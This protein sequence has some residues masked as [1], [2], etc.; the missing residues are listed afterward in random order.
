M[1][2][3]TAKTALY[4]IK[5]HDLKLLFKNPE[6]FWNGIVEIDNEGFYK[7][8]KLESII[9]PGSVKRILKSAFYSCSNLKEVV[10]EEGIEEISVAPFNYTDNIESIIFPGSA[11]VIPHNFCNHQRKLNKV[12][13]NEGVEE[14]KENAFRFCDR[15][16]KIELPESIISLEKNAF[17]FCD[18]L[19]EIKLGANIKNI[20]EGCF[21][22]DNNLRRI[23]LGKNLTEIN[24]YAFADCVR[25][26]EIEIEEGPT[27]IKREAFR[28]VGVSKLV[29]PGSVEIIEDKAF[30][31]CCNL[32]EIELKEGVKK[33][34][35]NIFEDCY[36]LEKVILPKSLE[37]IS[38]F[39][40]VDS[41]FNFIY[42][43]N[44]G[45]TIL[46][47]SKINDKNI[48]KEYS[49]KELN[50]V[51]TNFYY[52]PIILDEEKLDDLY[53]IVDKFKKE[54]IKI[55]G[56]MFLT[57]EELD[58]F[59]KN[60]NM[61]NYNRLLIKLS[62]N[63]DEYDV[64]SV[65]KFAQ[66]LGMFNKG[67]ILVKYEGNLLKSSELAYVSLKEALK[68]GK[69]KRSEL[70][71]KYNSKAL[72]ECAYDEELLLKFAKEIMNEK[73]NPLIQKNK[74]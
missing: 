47:K 20:G 50:S 62:K 6:L 2:K 23:H 40:F 55:P 21:Q 46:S 56:K 43:M 27:C 28:N 16:E 38:T 72:S 14:I 70:F 68:L 67:D 44:N 13:I 42:K 30:A 1:S 19:L 60:Y 69:I 25:L 45:Q 29:I 17:A 34:G 18:G 33:I 74:R 7:C 26:E 65:M 35:F 15:L 36:R 10:F 66:N 57:Y 73:K 48:V 37:K 53:K 4:R 63:F 64:S 71:K 31:N 39:N 51:V 8:D 9:V 61:F 12:T 3:K 22:G 24:E 49:L 32:S 11:K 5:N 41:R 58:I 59:V 52:Y 54:G